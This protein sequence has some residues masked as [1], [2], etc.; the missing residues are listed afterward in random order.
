M[1]F[2][3]QADKWY[4]LKLSV[5]QQDGKAVCLGKAWP[6]DQPEPKDWTIKLVDEVPNTHGS[7]GLWGFSND[8]EIYYDNIVVTLNGNAQA[9]A[10]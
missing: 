5:E 9:S 1:P 6:A 4:R 8:H 3:W 7:P 2:K 10:R